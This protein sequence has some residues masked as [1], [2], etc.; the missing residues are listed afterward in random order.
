MVSW[1]LGVHENSV[2][3][4]TLSR[5]V[6]R[7]ARRFELQCRGFFGG[8][9]PRT[10]MILLGRFPCLALLE[11]QGGGFHQVKAQNNFVCN[12]MEA[13]I[14]NYTCSMQSTEALMFFEADT[15]ICG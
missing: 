5:L 1:G 4:G 13:N 9:W 10:S 15:L 3:P 12:N 11:F 8:E 2:L 6:A 14:I 7:Q